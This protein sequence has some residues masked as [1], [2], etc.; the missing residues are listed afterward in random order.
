MYS[1]EEALR[2][3]ELDEQI[4]SE[5]E[6]MLPDVL[7]IFSKEKG[8]SCSIQSLHGTI[9]GKN[10]TY[11]DIVNNQF[12]DPNDFKTKW[13]K[14]LIEFINKSSYTPLKNL[15]KDKKFQDYTL[16][17]LERNFYRNLIERTRTKPDESLWTIWF[18]GGK[19]MWGLIIAPV[20]RSEIW[21]NDVSEIR[22]ADYMY[23]TVGH[24]MSTGLVDPENNEHYTFKD[25]NDLISFYQ[26]ILKRVSNSL[27]EKEIFDLYVNY[28]K[29]S[30]EPL[31]EPFLIPEFRYAGLAN[32]H[33]HRLDFTILNSHTMEL[34]GFEL[35]P[36]STHMA[37]SKMKDKTQKAVN[38]ELSKKWNKEMSKRNK[39]F[40]NFGITTITFSDD[41]LVDI[42]KCFKSFEQV[43]SKRP[44]EK[45]NLEK[46]LEELENI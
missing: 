43:L 14:G 1:K 28:L 34:I 15:M 27:Y 39:Y 19:F 6:K 42:P 16:L 4:T 41:D 30:K 18:G 21:T 23:W 8:R 3:K 22:R 45:L 20:L 7:K 12:S 13:I 2:I 40:E 24:V 5:L 11:T 29:H 36:T 25:I 44:S 35:S 32:A 10:N 31:Q 37:V 26:S 38:E 9:G 17:F 33:E 46:Q